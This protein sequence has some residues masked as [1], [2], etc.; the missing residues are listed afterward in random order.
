[1]RRLTGA[2]ALVVAFAFTV[3]A[4]GGGNGGDAKTTA[5]HDPVRIGTKNFTESEIIGELYKQALEAKGL[6]VDL[7]SA[8]GPTEVINTALR[9]GLLD[10][11]PEYI[12]VLLSEVDKI[13][14]RPTSADEAYDLAKQIEDR[15]KFTLL[16]QSRLSN[17]NA[18]AVKKSFS[19]RRGVTSI[20]D[21]KALRPPAR[22]GAAPEFLTRFEGMIGLR[23]RYGLRTL[24][25]DFADP[26]TGVRY[27]ALEEGKIDVASVF[28]TD[29]QLAGNR[30]VLLADPRGIFEKQHMAPIVSRKA[31]A[32]HGQVLATAVNAVSALLST[33]VM[34]ELNAKADVDK[35]TP[36]T[37]AREFLRTHGLTK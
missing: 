26:N 33:A 32:E 27:A 24:K 2:L 20:S 4:C 1:M 28:T 8:V 18:L 9:D 7:Q 14:D 23:Q 13:V 31:L 35:Q 3:A 12:G 25:T 19:T 16:D 6:T 17:E 5:D 10:M 11:Y 15:R 36:E 21:L 37:I 22:L 30:Y 29:S 34:R